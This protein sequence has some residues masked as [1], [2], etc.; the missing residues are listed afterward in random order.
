MWILCLVPD[1][2]GRP[3]W[4]C[5]FFR[6]G[7]PHNRT[8]VA[9]L[10]DAFQHMEHMRF[11]GIVTYKRVPRNPGDPPREY[12]SAE[13]VEKAHELGIPCVVV[14]ENVPWDFDAFNDVDPAWDEILGHFD[15]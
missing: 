4:F 5:P 2:G 11:N 3:A 12:N 8:A 10:A 7:K 9:S 15:Q 14:P 6:D 1:V 13:L